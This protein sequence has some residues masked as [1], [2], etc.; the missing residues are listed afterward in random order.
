MWDQ[1]ALTYSQSGYVTVIKGC[2]AY[3]FTN[4]GNDT[5]TVNNMVI[6]PSA[7]PASILGDSRTMSGHK[8]DLYYGQIRVSFAGVGNAPLVEIVQFYYITE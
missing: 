2:Y 5:V 7:V 6:F 3:M 1:S 4:L 8:N